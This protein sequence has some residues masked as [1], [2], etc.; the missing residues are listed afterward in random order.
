MKISKMTLFFGW[1]G[2][3]KHD[4]LDKVRWYQK[5]C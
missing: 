1:T 4:K 5:F 3:E 2:E